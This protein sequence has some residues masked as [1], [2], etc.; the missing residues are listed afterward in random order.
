[1]LKSTR[2]RSTGASILDISYGYDTGGAPHDPLVEI[3]EVAM[4]GFARA[5]EPGAFWVDSLP[6]RM[7]LHFVRKPSANSHTVKHLPAWM[8]GASFRRLARQMWADRQRMYDVPFEHTKAQMVRIHMLVHLYA[9]I[10]TSV[11]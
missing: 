9:L 3:V 8:P 5:S 2:C 6:L 4:D 7:L 1:M 10:L 11:M